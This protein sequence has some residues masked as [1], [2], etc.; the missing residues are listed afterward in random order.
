MRFTLPDNYALAAILLTVT[1]VI[2]IAIAVLTNP[3]EFVTAAFVV[4]GAA[5]AM[6]GIFILTFTRRKTAE[7][8][9][10]G[11][12]TAQWCKNMC[13]IESD[14]GIT[15]NAYFLPPRITGESRVMQF[16]PILTYSGSEVSAKEPL[17]K[18]GATGLIVPPSCEEWIQDLR[19]KNGLVIPNKE[20]ELIVLINEI[21]GEVFEF[22]TQVSGSW[23]DNTLTLTFKGYRFI[24]GC[25]SI[26]RESEEFCPMNPCPVCTLCGS[27]IAEG[28]DKVVTLDQC[29]IDASSRDVTATFSLLPFRT[30]P[31]HPAPLPADASAASS[32]GAVSPH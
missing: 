5:C 29:S 24:D 13:R 7:A 14:L 22:A 15:G 19:N 20:E 17:V 6:V 28:S 11:V 3:G 31:S 8:H 12:L 32:E 4:S 23:H 16:N 2:L 21:I 30:T 18:T 1:A 26:T 10:I 27:L 9:Q 25:K